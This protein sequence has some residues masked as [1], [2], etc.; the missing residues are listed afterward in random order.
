MQMWRVNIFAKVVCF[1]SVAPEHDIIIWIPLNLYVV[2]VCVCG[3]CCCD[4]K[5]RAWFKDKMS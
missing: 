4:T 3:R 1:M 2:C 5:E